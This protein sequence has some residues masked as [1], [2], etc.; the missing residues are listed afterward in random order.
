M[1]Y[2]HRA[3]DERQPDV[4]PENVLQPELSKSQL[5]TKAL[6]DAE[7]LLKDIAG[8]RK[9]AMRD[10]E[11]ILEHYPTKLDLLRMSEDHPML[12]AGMAQ[13]LI[14]RSHALNEPSGLDHR[15]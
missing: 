14:T 4:V 8:G 6:F 9:H 11:A 1:R 13:R 15:S 3:D 12:N 5:R 7:E 10:A 2:A